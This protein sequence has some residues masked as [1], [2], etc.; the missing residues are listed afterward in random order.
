MGSLV[1]G[2]SAPFHGPV[3]RP[4]GDARHNDE[5]ARVSQSAQCS[6]DDGFPCE[7]MRDTCMKILARIFH[8]QMVLGVVHTMNKAGYF[9]GDE[10]IGQ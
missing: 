3:V 9:G 8:S 7:V 5:E 1:G 10:R 4:R 6:D 2:S